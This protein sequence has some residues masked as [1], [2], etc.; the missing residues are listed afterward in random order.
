LLNEPQRCPRA[1]VADDQPAPEVEL[2]LLALM[3]SVEERGFV[4]LTRQSEVAPPDSLLARTQLVA[5][6]PRRR[7]ASDHLAS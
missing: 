1:N 2:G 5:P 3:L 7:L 6:K 4:I